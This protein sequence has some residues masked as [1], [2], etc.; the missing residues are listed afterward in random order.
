VSISPNACVVIDHKPHFIG[1]QELL[2]DATDNTKEL[3]RKELD[4]RLSELEDKWH[5]TSLEKIFFEEKIYKELEQ[6]HASWE[7]VN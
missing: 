5:Y 4:I 3:L 1:V 6:K 2:K 7:N